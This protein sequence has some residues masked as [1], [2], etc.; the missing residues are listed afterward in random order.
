ME[1]SGCL[2]ALPF[3]GRNRP[4]IIVRFLPAPG[5]IPW[6]EGHPP[7]VRI[8][9]RAKPKFVVLHTVH[10]V[11]EEGA[12]HFIGGHA[13]VFCQCQ[14]LFAQFKRDV[15]VPI[16]TVC[17]LPLS[18]APGRASAL[19][20][21]MSCRAASGIVSANSFRCASAAVPVSM[22]IR[23]IHSPP[24]PSTQS[25]PDGCIPAPH[26]CQDHAQRWSAQTQDTPPAQPRGGS[27]AKLRNSNWIAGLPNFGDVL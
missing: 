16:R 17:F 10:S 26:D 13:Q 24:T 27:G 8:G 3:S 12:C 22:S 20:I 5:L 4:G 14:N 7:P 9:M 21:P 25:P 18:I 11:F 23:G 6:K 1:L 2:R 19:S 15:D